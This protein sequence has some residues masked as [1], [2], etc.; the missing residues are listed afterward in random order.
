MARKQAKTANVVY[1]DYKDVKSLQPYLNH[2]NQIESRYKT[3][4]RETQQRQLARA[5]KKARHLALLPF[6]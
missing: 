2:F 1:F 6:V 5:I 3:G 4:L